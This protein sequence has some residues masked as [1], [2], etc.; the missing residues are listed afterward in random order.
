MNVFIGASPH[1]QGEETTFAQIVADELGFGVDD[2]KIV[3]GDT[4]NTPMGWGTYGSRT[5]AVGGAALAVATR[6]IKE[7]AKLLASHL[8]EAAV[9][10][11][12]YADGKFFVKGSPDR[13]KTIQDIAL[14]ANVAWNLPQG[15]E[16][17]LEASSFYDPPNFTYP[18]GA[19]VAVVEVEAATGKVELK[20]YV[21]VDD[22]GPQINPVIVEGQ[23]HGGVVQ[24]VGQALWEEAVYD[25]NGQLLTG[26]LADYAIPRA[27]VLPEIEVLSTVTPSPHHPLGVKGIGEAG[28]IA[29]TVHGLQRRDGRPATLRG[30]IAPDAADAGACLA[31]DWCARQEGRVIRLRVAT[32]RQAMY[33]PN[34]DYYRA[35]S[36]ADAHQLLAAHPGAKLLAGGHSLVPL[37]KL[38]LAAPSALV[39]IGRIAELRGISR[40][41]DVIRIGALTT[42][43]EL[44]A[45]A[46]LR[47]GAPALADA[48]AMVGDPAVRN[49]GTIGGNIAHADPASDLPTVL[50]A[51][52][53]RMV[54][55]G[56][57]GERTIPAEEFFTG[58]MTTALA[59]EEILTAIQVPASSPGQGSAYEKFAHP[60]SR[61]AVLGVAACITVANGTCSAARIALGGLLPN[62]RRASG[63]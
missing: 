20:R 26:S 6:K 36:V 16:A 61:Y 28:T 52:D 3:H 31:R 14:M 10:D 60:A 15:M 19:H 58:I 22:C 2:V 43:A 30:R 13:F 63:R 55:S 35:R 32:A 54:A 56:P 9:E 42:H 57:G 62:A 18:F 46:D 38:R 17:G 7:K 44:A 51:L 11:M 8:L 37:L 24:G 25:D 33:A 49:R 23:V 27:D 41:G 12:D 40:Q 4:D 45:S 48:A 47:R 29:S 1:G 50:V 39:D 53:A 21:A 59:E 5:T 34:F